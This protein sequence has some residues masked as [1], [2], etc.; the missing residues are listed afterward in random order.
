M[1]ALKG[2]VSLS[3]CRSDGQRFV[4]ADHVFAD[5]AFTDVEAKR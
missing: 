4:S 1:Y 5:A 2:G 3:L